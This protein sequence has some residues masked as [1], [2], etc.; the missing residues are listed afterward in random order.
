MQLP[1][2]LRRLSSPGSRGRSPP[3]RSLQGFDPG[4]WRLIDALLLTIAFLFRELHSLPGWGISLPSCW[5]NRLRNK[6][7]AVSPQTGGQGGVFV[8]AGGGEGGR[9]SSCAPLSHTCREHTD[10]IRALE[11]RLCE[12]CCC[13][14]EG[15]G[16]HTDAGDIKASGCRWRGSVLSAAYRLLEFTSHNKYINI[17]L[18][19]HPPCH[20]GSAAPPS[21]WHS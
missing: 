4:R 10:S 3:G 1:G 8:G 7:V 5:G 18:Y 6:K 11:G 9:L 12:R 20:S 19:M 17:S 21:P 13:Q 16:C 2:S 15:T 14:G